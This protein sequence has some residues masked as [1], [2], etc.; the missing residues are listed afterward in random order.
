MVKDRIATRCHESVEP[1]MAHFDQP[2]L[3]FL[4]EFVIT[5]KPVCFRL[6]VMLHNSTLSEHAA[7]HVVRD[8]SVVFDLALVVSHQ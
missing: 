1:L 8:L 2:L 7:N 5:S 4:G 6:F 3:L